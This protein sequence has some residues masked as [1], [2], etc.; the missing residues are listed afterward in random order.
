MLS[1]KSKLFKFFIPQ[2]LRGTNILC[3]VV[4]P[5]STQPKADNSTINSVYNDGS[6]FDNFDWYEQNLQFLDPLPILRVNVPVGTDLIR[7]SCPTYHNLDQTSINE[8][9]T[10]PTSGVIHTAEG[11]VLLRG[12]CRESFSE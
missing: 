5:A 6:K 2:I 11:R 1:A 9:K 4:T 7:Y 8:L 12:D 10:K 3:L